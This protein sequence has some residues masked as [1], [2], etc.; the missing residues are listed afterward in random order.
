MKK[1]NIFLPGKNLLFMIFC[2]FSEI[3]CCFCSK[4]WICLVF[5]GAMHAQSIKIVIEIIR[6]SQKTM[7]FKELGCKHI[8]VDKIFCISIRLFGLLVVI[9]D[10]FAWPI[11]I[12]GWFLSSFTTSLTSGSWLIAL[13][14]QFFFYFHDV[15]CF[16]ESL[17][18]TIPINWTFKKSLFDELRIISQVIPFLAN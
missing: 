5:F 14:R 7:G 18:S 8:V 9:F 3:F 4:R 15:L 1:V 11:I 2:E 13:Y 10:I 6:S 16:C 12:F 17:S